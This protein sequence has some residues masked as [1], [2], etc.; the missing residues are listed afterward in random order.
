MPDKIADT[1][2][3][4]QVLKG[5]QPRH[6]VAYKLFKGGI[7]IGPLMAGF[8][9][10]VYYILANDVTFKFL[11]SIINIVS[12]LCVGV[13]ILIFL[14]AIFIK[15]LFLRKCK[16]DNWVFDIAQKRL[17]TDVIY[18]DSH[19][20]YIQ[21]D[22][23]IKNTDKKDFVQEMSDKSENYS[24]F[25]VDTDIDAGVVIVECTK[26]S[27][28][29]KSAMFKQEDDRVWSCVPMGL[30]INTDTQKISPLD[31]K[32]NNAEK[33]EEAINAI[34][35]VHIL[36]SGSTGSGKSV[37]EQNIVRHVSM[38]PD[39][40][41]FLGVD[42]KRVEFINFIGVKGVKGVALD[43]YSAAD[44]TSACKDIMYQRQEFMAQHRANDIFKVDKLKLECNYYTLFGKDYQF[45]E[46]FYLE[47][48]LIQGD[49]SD[50]EFERMK[51]AYPK[52]RRPMFLTI[53]ELYKQID[54]LQGVQLYERKGY[55]SYITK[56][57]ITPT[58]GTYSHKCIIFQCDEL[59][60]LMTSDN[61]SCVDR[62]KDALGSIARLGRASDVHL[63]LACQ[64]ASGNT[65]SNDLM[66]N[67]KQKLLLGMFD[68][69]SS[70]LMF[71]KD[72]SHLAKPEI[73]GRGY[74]MIGTAMY[75]VQTYYTKPEADFKF[76]T[77]MKETYL[78]PYYID[79]C[80]MNNTTPDD[81]GWVEQIKPESKPLEPKQDD[82]QEN[83]DDFE[84]FLQKS[85]VSFNL[86]PKSVEQKVSFN[87]KPV[88]HNEQ[89]VQ[90]V[91]DVQNT[92]PEHKKLV[93]HIIK[94]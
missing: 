88:E 55:N 47:T 3:Y 58:K 74:M 2:E 1:H 18:Y 83:D 19:R 53:E 60:E 68:S 39:K 5:V 11:L 6:Q 52:G 75:E 16:F 81:T 50:R 56:K 66:N 36:I 10:A 94:K 78:N 65:I 90:N 64:R 21:Y 69:G 35:S 73:K 80:K 92:T 12:F 79:Q 93:I 14:L 76:D 28:I 46:I 86:K 63:V 87:L 34:D 17:G 20:L 30:S 33:D 9:I 42:L 67:I 57:D 29:P 7:I 77:D 32:I 91:P 38:Y 82:N 89:V 48:D 51:L 49:M 27:P 59:N 62:V 23:S 70:T 37:A 84:S 43:I 24:Y 26:R 71:E 72:I 15:L 8:G 41:Q 61:Y 85:Q 54:N 44:C 13:G 45:D 4:E 25:Y 31:W 40:F 22:R